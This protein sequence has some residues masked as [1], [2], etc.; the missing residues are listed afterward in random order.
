MG[1]RLRLGS[2]GRSR[3]ALVRSSAA[4][5]VAVT[6]LASCGGPDAVSAPGNA[7][8]DDSRA[9]VQ[10]PTD[11]GSF[12]SD[13]DLDLDLADGMEGWTGDGTS[14]DQGLL[15]APGEDQGA[16]VA[17]SSYA[18]DPA[19]SAVMVEADM[20]LPDAPGAG[21]GVWCAA[22][23]DLVDGYAFVAGREGGW[24]LLR[25]DDGVATQL[26]R[27]AFDPDDIP[28]GSVLL[29]LACSATVGDGA[30][31]GIG[32]DAQPFVLVR[33]DVAPPGPVTSVGVLSSRDGIDASG[34]PATLRR[35]TIRGG[36][37]ER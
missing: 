17:A 23:E 9:A 35:F 19:G 22:G 11:P 31:L 30:V 33:D 10:P 1:T 24:A 21:G 18:V 25:Y 8:P 29:R 4:G 20:V 16:A 2:G 5:L 27:G 3:R 26:E 14:S 15:L 34:A 32:Y 28:G 36:E 7:D 12:P 6:A 13:P 37:T